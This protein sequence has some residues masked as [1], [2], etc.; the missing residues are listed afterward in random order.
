MTLERRPTAKGRPAATRPTGFHWKLA[1]IVEDRGFKASVEL[2]PLLAERGIVLS[3]AQVYRLINQTPERLSL[4]TLAALCD[5]FDCTPNDLIIPFVEG[6][7]QLRPAAGE[8]RGIKKNDPGSRNP[9]LPDSFVPEKADL[10]HTW[11]SR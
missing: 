2:G 1:Q 3:D 9:D 10:G 6:I 4:K 8:R 11:K 7:K 5:I